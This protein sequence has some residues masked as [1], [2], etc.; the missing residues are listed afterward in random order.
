MTI[1]SKMTLIEGLIG[2]IQSADIGY[3]EGAISIELEM[4]EYT[5]PET[6]AQRARGVVSYG[7]PEGM[8]DDCVVALAL[9]TKKW[10]EVKASSKPLIY[11]GRSLGLYDDD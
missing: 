7:A 6:D 9:A 10:R 8:H 4:F 11:T 5:Y 2:A 1:G 3:P